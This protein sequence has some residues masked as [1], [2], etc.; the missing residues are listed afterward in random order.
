[1]FNS[2]FKNYRILFFAIFAIF[3]F[4]LSFQISKSFLAKGKEKINPNLEFQAYEDGFTQSMVVACGDMNNDGMDE[5]VTV[6]SNNNSN[7]RIFDYKGNMLDSFD[8]NLRLNAQNFNNVA[9]GDVDGDKKGEIVIVSRENDSLFKIIKDKRIISES[10]AFKGLKIGASLALGD[11]NSNG[12]DEIIIGAGKGGGPQIKIFNYRMEELASFFAFSPN[13]REGINIAVGNVDND[14]KEE[15][16][17]SPK[18]GGQ[19]IVRIYKLDDMKR[20]TNTF[21]AYPKSMEMGVKI[22]SSDLDNDN[23]VEIITARDVDD[24]NKEIKIFDSDGNEKEARFDAFLNIGDK[25]EF[26]IC[27]F[28]DGKRIVLN[29]KKKGD[30][31][32]KIIHNN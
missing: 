9:L 20:F 3:I 30:S 19:G 8:V 17:V 10:R 1:M 24:I 21:W 25:N 31:K 18:K 16:I 7:I 29:T 13:S 23:K 28:Q 12:K 15:I 11:L 22:A 4:F 14:V 32:I 5:I 6:S 2:K 27:D 26:N